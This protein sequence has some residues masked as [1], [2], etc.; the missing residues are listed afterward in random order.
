[1]AKVSTKQMLTMLLEDLQ[2]NIRQAFAEAIATGDP[3]AVRK[4]QAAELLISRIHGKAVTP[5]RD[6]NLEMPRDLEELKHMSP[7][8]RR[9]LLKQQSHLRLIDDESTEEAI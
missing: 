7:E 6:E 2:D 9:Q 4:A 5:T 8:E 3:E 1:M